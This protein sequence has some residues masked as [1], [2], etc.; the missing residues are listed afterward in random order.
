MA[1]LA[2]A[3]VLSD[4]YGRVTVVDRDIL[5]DAAAPRKGVPQ[6]RHAHALLGGGARAIESLFPGIIGELNAD[7]ATE[8]LF[9]DGV[10]F[11]AGGYRAPILFRRNVVGASR[12]FI[13]QHLRDRVRA[14]TNV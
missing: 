14:L 4:H 8:L 3:R 5:P 12:P 13:E 2:A 7:G 9:N 10:W 11:Q 6:S 1:G